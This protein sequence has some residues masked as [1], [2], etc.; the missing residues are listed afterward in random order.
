MKEK[1]LYTI[2]RIGILLMANVICSILAITLVSWV[3]NLFVTGSGGKIKIKEAFFESGGV[4]SFVAWIL[5]LLILLILFI[6]DGVKHSAYESYDSTS[7]SIVLILLFAVY[8]VPV[9]FMSRTSGN[10]RT[11]FKGFYF[12]CKWIS[13]RF[14]LSYEVS[15]LISIGIILILCLAGYVLAHAIYMK[16]HP[17]LD[18]RV[19]NPNEE[20]ASK[21]E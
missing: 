13:E 5:V 9:L 3:S 7:T 17:V 4:Y 21:D 14:S 2:A 8:Y 15:A 18:W 19:K 20:Y 16:K 11:G 12:P 1:I 10:T 6:D